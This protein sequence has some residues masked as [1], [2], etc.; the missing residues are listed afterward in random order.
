MNSSSANMDA[1]VFS[2]R[3]PLISFYL[4]MVASMGLGTVSLGNVGGGNIRLWEIFLVAVLAGLLIKIL[5][6][7]RLVL[8][9]R[10]SIV[11]VTFF[12]LSVLLSGLNAFDLYLYIKQTLLLFAMLV[13]FLVV[14]QR[15]SANQLIQNLRWVAYPG[16][17]VAGWGVLEF[18]L[19]PETLQVYSAELGLWPRACAFFA[20]ANEFSQY[21]VVPFGFV[22][23]TIFYYKP[24]R[25][26]ETCFLGIGL[27]VIAIAQI[28]SFSRGGILSFVAQLIAWLILSNISK[29]RV[30]RQVMQFMKFVLI[31]ILAI[32]ISCLIQPLFMDI[33][34]VLFERIASL[35]LTG[36]STTL[37]RFETISTAFSATTNSLSSFVVGIGFG[38]LPTILGEGIANTGN[39]LTDVFS[40][41]GLIGLIA[42]CGIVAAFLFL[43]IRT[44]RILIQTNNHKLLAVFY[45]AY[46][47][48]VG[49]AVGGMTSPTHMLNLFWF[50]GGVLMALYQYGRNLA[51]KIK[52]QGIVA[53]SPS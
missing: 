37:T 15:S 45:G 53:N 2:T 44:H 39:F 31:L 10:V 3:P 33:L 34:S 47:S 26:W 52:N 11:L 9:S 35:F 32:G 28:L 23:A 5:L 46:L 41:A 38:N 50:S 51:G 14:A 22:L 27:V 25:W 17:L 36:D 13:L 12:A 4:L 21:L 48:F 6:K 1:E 43:P 8:A 16:I 24:L 18:F 40:E 42:I 30:T 20:E 7:P 29:K 49:L 19:Y